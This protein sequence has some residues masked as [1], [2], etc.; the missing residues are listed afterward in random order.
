MSE[1]HY[2]K[3]RIERVAEK[4]LA[5]AILK[6]ARLHPHLDEY[7]KVLDVGCSVGALLLE[8]EKL[9]DWDNMAGADVSP[10]AKE[11]WQPSS[12][13][14]LFTDDFTT[15]P[16]VPV[17]GSVTRD[18][19]VCTEV[20]EHLPKRFADNLLRRVTMP[21]QHDSALVF[22]AA[23]PGQRGNGHVNCQPPEHWR[24]RLEEMGWHYDHIMT[25]RFL[26]DLGR[27]NPG[28]TWNVPMCYLNTM[29]FLR[30]PR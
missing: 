5:A 3:K 1:K 22:G 28:R 13:A 27:A 10:Y 23:V 2:H 29:V 19:I 7:T 9:K 8:M 25:S 6:T 18:L 26:H 30:S 17:Y 16:P 14:T 24:V 20:M 15:I 21:W 11:F 4:H 12:A